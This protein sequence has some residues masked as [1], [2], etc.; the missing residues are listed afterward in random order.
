MIFINWLKELTLFSLTMVMV[1]AIFAGTFFVQ[2]SNS[3][4]E[5]VREAS[6]QISPAAFEP[7]EVYPG[8]K[9]TSKK[10][11]RNANAFSHSSGNMGFEKELLFKVGNG[12]FRKLWVSS[13]SSTTS[14]DGLGP[15]FNARSCQRCHLKDGRG[16]T[17]S[18][19]YPDDSQVSMFLRLSV[20]PQNKEQQALIES[21]RANVI[22]E[23]T[24]GTQLQDLS[25]Q[26]HL[27]EGHMDIHYESL[28]VSF[29][30]GS[31]IELR[32]PFYSISQLNYGPLHKDTR[33][34][35]RVTPP[36]IG[37]GLLEAI[38]AD[39]ILAGA[40]EVDKDGDGISGRA[41][42]V[43]S[44][45]QNKMMLGR[46]GWKAGEATIKDQSAGAF[47]G[48]LGL[49]NPLK[50]SSYGDCTETQS[51]CRK[52]PDGASPEHGVEVS[53]EMLD[54]VVFYAKNLAVP[55][56]RKADDEQV[57]KGK[58]LF[59][60]S[61]CASCHR[62]KFKTGPSEGNSHLEGQIIFPYTDMLLH[63]MGEALADHRPE[64]KADG[65]EWRTAPLWGI[66]L[67]KKVNGHEFLL[68]DGR[69]RSIEE[70]IVWHGGEG[71]AAR[72]AY[73]K[74]SKQEREWLVEFIRSL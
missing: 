14:S 69:A 5:D 53:P 56:R 44:G 35:P 50:K 62:P 25:I 18:A 22:G 4:A 6:A 21:G 23:P 63:D 67:T 74:L 49:S 40:D 60:Q 59:H 10:S 51:F 9:A 68:H 33:I 37:L 42:M 24:Y 66:G 55:K 7:E 13:P 54:L 29:A 73:L 1:P 38:P 12:L 28:K 19:N 32:N 48:D 45:D 64:G 47:A 52:A 61:G 36:M 58:A 27:A 11:V 39:N 2:Y 71:L 72:N 70:A 41:N 3:S 17:P 31:E 34:S 65:F 8:G 20:P 57:L 16:H 26:G 43:W 15:L 30:D 46:F